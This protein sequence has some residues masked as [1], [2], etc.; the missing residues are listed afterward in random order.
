LSSPRPAPTSIGGIGKGTIIR[1]LDALDAVP[2]KVVDKAGIQNRVLNASKGPAVWG[3]RA[4]IDRS[5]Y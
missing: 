4:Q 3:P 2:G 5:L 1:E